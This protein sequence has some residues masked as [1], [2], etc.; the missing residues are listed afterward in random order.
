MSN[1]NSN[2][3]PEMKNASSGV[4]VDIYTYLKNAGEFHKGRVYSFVIGQQIYDAARG[5]STLKEPLQAVCE[6]VDYNQGTFRSVDEKGQPV[7]DRFVSIEEE[8]E[9]VHVM[10]FGVLKSQ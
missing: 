4:K 10:T 9:P 8:A 2:S 5:L 3:N 7:W 1:S 6:N